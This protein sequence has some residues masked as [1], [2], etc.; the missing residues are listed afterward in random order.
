MSVI[1]LEVIEGCI[2]DQIYWHLDQQKLLPEEQKGCM[3][4]S[5]ENN[6]LLCIDRAVIRE[7]KSKKKNLVIA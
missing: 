6:D 5:R 3:K 7:V 1:N 4:R 2:E